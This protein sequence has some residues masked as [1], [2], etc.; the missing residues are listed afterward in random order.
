MDLNSLPTLVT[1]SLFTAILIQDLIRA[2]YKYILGHFLFG[3]ISVLLILY[4]TEASG[5]FVAWGVLLLPFALLILGISIDSVQKASGKT[6][7]ASLAPPATPRGPC[8]C[9][10]CAS[11]PC[12]CNYKKEAAAIDASGCDVD[13][14]EEGAAPSAEETK[15][16]SAAAAAPADST[17]SESCGPGSTSGKT[18]CLNTSTLTEAM[19]I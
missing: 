15:S 9:S 12:I 8:G 18:Q 6:A 5:T 7:E 13:T 11:C 1:V 4:V 2:N 14:G 3:I 17:K 19:G 16:S 10:Q